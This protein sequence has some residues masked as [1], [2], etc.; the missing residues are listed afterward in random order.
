MKA[1]II[2]ES[3]LPNLGGV[4]KHIAGIKPYLEKE[5][6]ELTIF[7]KKEIFKNRPL[8]KFIGLLQIWLELAKRIQLIKQ[9]DI[10]FIHDVFIYY[11]PFRIIF[12]RKKIIT[13]FHGWEKIYPIP[14]KNILYKQLAQKLSNKTISIGTYINK[15]YHLHNKNNY[16]SY[17]AVKISTTQVDL[18]KKEKNSFLFIGRL[19]KDTGLPIFLDFLNI[20]LKKKIIFSVKFCGDGPMKKNCLRYGPVLGFVDVKKY[21]TKSEFC[22]AGGYLSILEAMI[23]KNIVLSAFNNELK[24]DYLLDSPFKN[25]IICAGQAETLFDQYVDVQNR[26]KLL[27]INYHLAKKYSFEQ[28]ANLYIQLSQS[29]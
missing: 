1:L 27:D 16:L 19:E 12:P 15:Y 9:A 2:T 14:L 17:G 18:T 26:Q 8:R 6:F 4:E 20:L 22:F 13:T 7:S 25:N 11:L 28:L 21:L 29:R 3:Y 10:I 5:G 24:K 23:Y